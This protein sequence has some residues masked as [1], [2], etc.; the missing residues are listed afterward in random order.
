M[1]T[2][3]LLTG[4][5]ADAYNFFIYLVTLIMT[6]MAAAAAAFVIGVL[7]DVV[8]LANIAAVFT[9]VFMLVCIYYAINNAYYRSNL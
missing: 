9:Y 6:S 4:L 2:H 7:V 5:E 3:T 8:A 1:F